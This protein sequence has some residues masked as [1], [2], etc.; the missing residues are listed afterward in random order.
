MYVN[1]W[2]LWDFSKQYL[3]VV[4]AFTIKHAN[5]SA[6]LWIKSSFPFSVHSYVYTMVVCQYLCL[7]N[8]YCPW[9]S[10]QPIQNELLLC[11]P[12]KHET[13]CHKATCQWS[14][15]QSSRLTKDWPGASVPLFASNTLM[16][17]VK[18]SNA[19]WLP[20]G[21]NNGI[22]NLVVLSDINKHS[23]N[24]EQTCSTSRCAL[25]CSRTNQTSWNDSQNKTL[26]THTEWQT[27]RGKWKMIVLIM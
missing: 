11:H 20:S 19:L 17:V 7:W 16:R 2:F 27:K 1:I 4:K 6:S 14:V 12:V 13:E 25:T 5:D 22:F 8:M 24:G 9:Q 3:N 18:L 15:K 26:N 21:T 23:C 10:K